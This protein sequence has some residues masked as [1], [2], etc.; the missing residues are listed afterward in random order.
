MQKS[1]PWIANHDRE[2]NDYANA[3]RPRRF[4]WCDFSTNFILFPMLDTFYLSGFF[5]GYYLNKF[6]FE[7]PQNITWTD[8]R[9]LGREHSW[10]VSKKFIGN[11]NFWGITLTNE[12]S[13]IAL[14]DASS[15][16]FKDVRAHC[17]CASLVRTLF[18]G[19]ARAESF[20][21]ARTDSKTQQNIERMK[22]KTQTAV[23][24]ILNLHIMTWRFVCT[25]H[26]F[27]KVTV[28]I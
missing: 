26:T 28:E 11:F 16:L 13:W 14:S 19:H 12:N 18:I 10:K 17:Y 24:N 6:C 25:L 22:N 8:E 5:P 23:I 21:S 3:L 20:S 4:N 1:V 27:S 7:L 2:N 9:V 15:F